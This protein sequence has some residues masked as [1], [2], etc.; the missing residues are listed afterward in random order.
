[1][2]MLL[3]VKEVWPMYM[4]EWKR[5]GLYALVQVTGVLPMCMSVKEAWCMFMSVPVMGCGLF[6]CQFE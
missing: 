5:C 6:A 3:L 1:M 4:S 2:Y